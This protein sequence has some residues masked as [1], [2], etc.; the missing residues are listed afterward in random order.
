MFDTI[1][2]LRKRSPPPDYP[3][4][5]LPQG[6]AMFTRGVPLEGHFV[7]PQHAISMQDKYD[8]HPAVEANFVAVKTEFAKEEEKSFHI[9]F[10][11]FL[12]YFI[13]GLLL[14]PLQ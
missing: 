4:L 6:K 5:D 12:I 14:N 7:C 3:P 9:H 2:V 10:P 11:R 8:N 1:V 13:V